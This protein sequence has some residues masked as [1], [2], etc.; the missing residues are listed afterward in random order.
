WL[1]RSHRRRSTV[2]LLLERD[3]RLLLPRALR[4]RAPRSRAI[5]LG[6]SS[7]VLFEPDLGHSLDGMPNIITSALGERWLACFCCSR[8]GIFRCGISVN[9]N[10]KLTGTRLLSVQRHGGLTDHARYV[11]VTVDSGFCRREHCDRERD[12]DDQK[13]LHLCVPSA[14]SGIGLILHGMTCTYETT[15]RQSCCPWGR[16]QSMRA[17]TLRL[18]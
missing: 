18:L 17:S 5:S 6:F 3:I 1:L 10:A 16:R 4:S 15:Q 13:E 8:Q 7:G 12:T 9:M 2:Q 11:L 14:I